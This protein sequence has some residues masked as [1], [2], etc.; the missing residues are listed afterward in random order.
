MRPMCLTVRLGHTTSFARLT[1][2]PTYGRLPFAMQPQ[3]QEARFRTGGAESRRLC[4]IDSAI[5]SASV[6][7][8]GQAV[9][10]GVQRRSLA[11]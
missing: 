7:S 11:S 6:V 9:A 5:L 3:V 1:D 4:L 10:R 8:G 2:A